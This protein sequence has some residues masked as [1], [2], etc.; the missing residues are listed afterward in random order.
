M[1]REA[2][3]GSSDSLYKSQINNLPLFAPMEGRK[4]RIRLAKIQNWNP[5]DPTVPLNIL[6]YSQA[7]EEPIAAHSVRAC[8]IVDYLHIG[9]SLV[10]DYIPGQP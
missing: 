2:A 5:N 4:I 8:L 1:G 9:A 10:V 7:S 6:L 3:A